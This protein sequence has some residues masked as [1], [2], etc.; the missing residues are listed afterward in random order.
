MLL[1]INRA[2]G[3]GRIRTALGPAPRPKLAGLAS[4]SLC[5]GLRAAE[6]FASTNQAIQAD[7]LTSVPSLLR[8]SEGR[9]RELDVNLDRPVRPVYMCSQLAMVE[10]SCKL[11]DHFCYIQHS[12]SQASSEFRALSSDKPL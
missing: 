12:S 11:S 7:I 10:P 4:R 6:N 5:R 2:P 1:M 8:Q 9:P 3:T